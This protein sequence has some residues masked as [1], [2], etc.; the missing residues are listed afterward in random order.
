MGKVIAVLSF[1]GTSLLLA[2][3]QLT[4]FAELDVQ[5]SCFIWIVV[6]LSVVA[7]LTT[8]F[9]KVK[10]RFGI[11]DA[12]VVLF[13]VWLFI[14]HQFVSPIN[15]SAKW[16]QTVYFMILYGSLRMILPVYLQM[17]KFLFVGIVICGLWESVVGLMQVVGVC[18]S[19]HHLFTF[20][21]TFVNTGPYGGFLAITMSIAF[22]FL[23]VQYQKFN[24]LCS[25]LKRFPVTIIQNPLFAVY[26]LCGLSFCASFLT[27]FA[28]MSRAAI[29]G[30]LISI[31]TI[32][33]T[34]NKAKLFLSN[35]FKV[36]RKK[37]I[38]ISVTAFTVVFIGIGATYY[39]KKESA[40]ARVLIWTVSCNA[41]AKQPLLGSGFGAF[42]GTYSVESVD[43]F[44]KHPSS[45]AI[46]VAD[47]PEYSFNE[48][49]QTGV[50]TG[51]VGMLLLISIL[52][53]AL[54]KLIKAK[55]FFAYGLIVVLVFAFFSYPFSQL[56]FQILLV[57][58]LASSAR[59]RKECAC[60]STWHRIPSIS[61]CIVLIVAAWGFSGLY[62]EKIEATK[63]WKQ[64]KPLYSMQS[65]DAA[66]LEYATLYHLLKDNPRFLFEYGH[67]LH[68]TG[69]FT[70]SNAILKEGA[71]Y[72]SDPMF[73]NVIGN[74]FKE[75]G[76]H[77]RAEEMYRFAFDMLPNRIYPL[78]LLMK[79]YAETNQ[80]D[81]AFE[82][83]QKIIEFVPKVD[84]PAVRDIKEEAKK[85][86]K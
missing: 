16:L 76:E 52:L 49:L 19:H 37:T 31:V 8:F 2:V 20:T 24:K 72:S 68:K 65:Y 28:A 45:Q 13:F 50:E 60:E 22:G 38:T 55:S 54:Y 51:I 6:G 42:F 5:D 17:E 4:T 26:L 7:I 18:S 21:G 69:R 10:S 11:I 86:F 39:L 43:Y 41:I 14:N 59:Y 34:Q 78:Y 53:L 35:L 47:V 77:D 32:I 73:Y 1:I 27:F 83:A 29:I 80:S 84:S 3:T 15:A 64:I 79:L 85:L 33:L 23:V 44:T 71:Q 46:A 25:L 57:L 9:S 81:K 82:M 61:I 63:A 12:L 58:F 62:Q 75:L 36:H 66:R 48:Y 56:P 70:Q 30:L 40:D 67:A 74:N